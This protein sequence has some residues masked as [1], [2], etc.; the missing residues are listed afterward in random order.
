MGSPCF[1]RGLGECRQGVLAASADGD[2]V[3]DAAS[4]ARRKRKATWWVG[5]ERKAGQALGASNS[6]GSRSSSAQ[7]VF[8]SRGGGDAGEHGGGEQAEGASGSTRRRKSSRRGV[9]RQS[10]DAQ[11]GHARGEEPALR[12]SR[13]GKEPALRF[14]GRGG[15][16]AKG[17]WDGERRGKGPAG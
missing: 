13:R 11:G 17:G 6:P 1:C 5:R 4:R 14:T 16:T 10:S 7:R 2:E 3:V 12:K 9:G 8:L 15:A